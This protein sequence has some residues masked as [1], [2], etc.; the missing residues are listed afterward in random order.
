MTVKELIAALMEFP[1]EASVFI[2]EESEGGDRVEEVT[3][4][5]Y[6]RGYTCVSIGK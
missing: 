3:V 5:K 1:E 4:E 6:P 2:G